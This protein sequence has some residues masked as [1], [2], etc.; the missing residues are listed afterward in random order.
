MDGIHS[1]ILTRLTSISLTVTT[2][3]V[4][5]NT[6]YNTNCPLAPITKILYNNRQKFTS[7]KTEKYHIYKK[8]KKTT[9]LMTKISQNI[10]TP[11]ELLSQLEQ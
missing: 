10:T 3:P 8:N 4:S 5:H 2:T 7:Q 1:V 6:C 11:G 9:K